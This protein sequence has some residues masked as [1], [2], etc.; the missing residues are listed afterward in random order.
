MDFTLKTYE[1]FLKKLSENKIS[2]YG[3]AD[4]IKLKPKNGIL[5]RHD[6]DRKPKNSLKVA[7][8]EKKYNIL[9]SY[10]FRIV[11][12]SFNSSIIKN[13]GN[14]NHEIGYHY[15]DLSLAKGDYKRAINLFENHLNQFREICSITTISMHGRPLSPYDN[16]DL[17]KTYNFEDYKIFGEAFLSIDYSDM[18]YFTD[19]GRSWS[20]DSLN[21][22]DNVKNS[23]QADLKNTASL[24]QFILNNKNAKIAVITHPERWSN[25]LIE[26][27]IDSL[28]DS[29]INMIKRV[30]KF[31]RK[32]DD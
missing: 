32:N 21:L 17:W 6:V 13:I 10:Y 7:E 25:T 15:E 11:K 2:V 12:S 28:K 29:V 22:R 14:Y 24:I 31:I 26:H 23:L 3:I 19:T 30:I 4:W 18:Y 5:L 16:R 27:L 1:D 9:S 8:L 20:N